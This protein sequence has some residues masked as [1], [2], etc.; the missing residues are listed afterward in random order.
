MDLVALSCFIVSGYMKIR[1]T[2]VKAM[3]ARPKFPARTE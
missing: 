2:T 3:M 1:I